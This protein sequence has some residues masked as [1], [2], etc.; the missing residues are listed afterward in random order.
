MLVVESQAGYSHLLTYQSRTLSHHTLSF[1]S[2]VFVSAVL[3]VLCFTSPT[4]SVLE[5][6]FLVAEISVKLF[7]T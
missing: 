2:I 5:V 6:I 3:M 4:F 1:S 7:A